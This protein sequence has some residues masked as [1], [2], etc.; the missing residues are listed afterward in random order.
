MFRGVSLHNTK[1]GTPRTSFRHNGRNIRRNVYR[2]E[3]GNNGRRGNVR[4]SRDDIRRRDNH[5][6]D[7]DDNDT[8]YDSG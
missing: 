7:P 1:L 5:D 2:N 4:R 3:D 6:H 8:D